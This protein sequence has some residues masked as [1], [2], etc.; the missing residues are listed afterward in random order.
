MLTIEQV[1]ALD[2]KVRMAVELIDSLRSENSALRG[3]LDE[4]KKRIDEL[5]N[6]VDSF[7]LDQME[8]EEGIMD[9]LVQLDK[10]EDQITAPS[11]PAAPEAAEETVEIQ[12]TSEVVVEE[13]VSETAA[14]VEE[15]IESVQ[16]V[17][18]QAQPVAAAAEPVAVSSAP[19]QQ[20]AVE[21]RKAPELEIF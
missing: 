14:P 6:V 8:I 9:V 15:N 7:K 21:E 10:L 12:Q 13:A 4:Y 3:K 16:P 18:Q 11:A 17:M 5:E 1:R 2:E 19:L 20:P